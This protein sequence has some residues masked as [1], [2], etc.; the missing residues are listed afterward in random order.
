MVSATSQG[1]A[2]NGSRIAD[3][4]ATRVSRYGVSAYT[5]VALVTPGPSPQPRVRRRYTTPAPAAKMIVPHQMRWAAQSGTPA[6]SRS[7]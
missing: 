5:N 4:R 7:Q 3:R 1:S 2:T 6:Q